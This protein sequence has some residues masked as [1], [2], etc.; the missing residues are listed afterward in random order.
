MTAQ[1]LQACFWFAGSKLSIIPLKCSNVSNSRVKFE[2]FVVRPLYR[3]IWWIFF[4]FSIIITFYDLY[5][6]FT[7][8]KTINLVRIVYHI[9]LLLV[10]TATTIMAFVFQG[11]SSDICTLLIVLSHQSS[12]MLRNKCSASHKNQLNIFIIFLW[13][14]TFGVGV[15]HLIITPSFEIAFPCLHNNPLVPILFSDCTSPLFRIT[16]YLIQILFMLPV[17]AISITVYSMVFVIL[18]EITNKLKNLL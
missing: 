4:I 1:V 7:Y 17:S 18:S 5:H 16:V 6:S 8:Y 14:S 3:Y 12:Q 13:T 9:F 15:F 11:Q 2:H 10:K